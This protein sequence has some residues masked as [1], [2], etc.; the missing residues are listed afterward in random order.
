MQGGIEELDLCGRDSEYLNGSNLEAVY[1]YG[2]LKNTRI[3]I[4]AAEFIWGLST[5]QKRPA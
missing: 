5:K 1:I 4:R 2:L 3:Y